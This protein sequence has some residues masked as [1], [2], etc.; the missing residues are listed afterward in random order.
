MNIELKNNIK[1]E[2]YNNLREQVGGIKVKDETNK[3]K[4]VIPSLEY[5][6]QVMNYRKIFLENNESFDGCSGLEECETYEEWLDFENRL[7]KKYQ[8]N[9]VQSTVYLAIRL[10]DNK[11]IGI[12]DF[13]HKLTDFLYN[14]GGN[15]GYS[16]LPKERRKGYA[17]E[18]LKLMLEYCKSIKVR[19]VLLCCDKEN[20]GSSKA[21][22]ANGGILENEV[23][24]E[25][26]LTESGIIQR[27]WIS[28]KKRFADSIERFQDVE[29]M[30]RKIININCDDF[31]GDICLNMFKK[32]KSRYMIEDTKLCIADNGYKWLEFYD[33]N[34][35]IKLTTM[36]DENNEI[37]EWYFDISRKI[38][39]ENGIPYEDDLY[40]DVVLTPNGKTFLLD[41]DELKQAYERRE[42]TKEE[43]DEAYRLAND[44]IHKINGRQI[45]MKEFT[46]KYLKE[47]GVD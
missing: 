13:R 29:E 17:K 14:Y 11:L 18:M 42:L 31:K 37:V 26:N 19:R 38:G 44:L 21:I 30:K 5:K 46:N 1:V 23:I 47:I 15:I 25:V 10:S 16:V 27:Y 2:E 36:Y 8:K 4:L 12:I 9:Y 6:E 40:L 24:D 33:Y 28:L 32:M 43:Y 7:S 22:I 39:K 3:L 45:E 34:S 35:K 20:I 41:E